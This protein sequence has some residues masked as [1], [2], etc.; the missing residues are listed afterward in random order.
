MTL[1]ILSGILALVVAGCS[2]VVWAARGGPRWTRAVSRATLAAA[3]AARATQ[4]ADRKG[5]NGGDGNG[6]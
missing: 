5:R 6:D 2:C 3:D 1:L 4:R